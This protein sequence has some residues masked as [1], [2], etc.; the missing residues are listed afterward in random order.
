MCR[1]QYLFQSQYENRKIIDDVTINISE[2]TKTA[3]VGP[4]GDSKT[5]LTSLKARF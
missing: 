3:I 2:K 1:I 5:T 4:S